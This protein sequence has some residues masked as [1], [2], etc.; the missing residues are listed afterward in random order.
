MNSYLK[1][2]LHEEIPLSKAI[3]LEVLNA[4]PLQVCL[5]APLENNINHKLTA[6][7]GSLYCLAVLSCWSVVYLQL[8]QKNISAHIVIQDGNMNYLKPVSDDIVADCSLESQSMLD[9]SLRMLERKGR[10]RVTLKS[11]I[12]QSGLVA[13]TFVG[14]FVVH[15]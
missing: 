1:A 15:V 6:F 2:L 10:A 14:R 9:K 7:G 8:K 5:H 11:E 3:G 4:S 12:K 13:V